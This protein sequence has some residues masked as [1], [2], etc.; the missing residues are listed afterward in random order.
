V[1]DGTI[2]LSSAVTVVT[3]ANRGLGRQLARQ[4]LARGAKVYAT[5]RRPETVDLPGALVFPLDITDPAS[6]AAAAEIATDSTVLIN[7]AGTS[8]G[9]A[10]PLT[11]T[12]R[13]RQPSYAGKE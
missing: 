7:N 6:I 11:Q 5:D 3:G 12:A 1:I 9:A 4:L 10:F 2:D 8:T 13:L